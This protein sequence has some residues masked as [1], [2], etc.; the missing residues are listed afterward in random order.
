MATPSAPRDDLVRA[1]DT[2]VEFRAASDDSDDDGLGTLHGHFSVFGQPY[3]IDSVFEGRFMEVIAPGAF[4]DTIAQDRASMRV[5]FQHGQDPHIGSKPLGSIEELEED[6]TGARYSAKLLDTG[7][8][9]DLLPGLKA[10][11]YGASMRFTVLD[12]QWDDE[13]RKS[14]SNPDKLPERTITRARVA[15]FGPVTFPASPSATAGVRSL[16]D[17]FRAPPEERIEPAA[18]ATP[19]P[20]PK[21]TPVEV[22]KPATPADPIDEY[23]SVPE[24][25]EAV[26]ARKERM[27]ELDKEHEG[28]ELPPDAQAEFDTADTE[29][30]RLDARIEAVEKRR[31]QVEEAEARATHIPVGTDTP[32]PYSPPV[33]VPTRTDAELTDISHIRAISRSDDEYRQLMRDNAMRVLERT[34]APTDGKDFAADL[35][36]HK[37]TNDRQLARRVLAT[38]SPAYMRAFRKY[39]LGD[40]FTAEEQRAASLAVGVD[41]T[42]GFAVPF[43]FDPSILKTGAHAPNPYRQACRVETIVGTDTW[44]GVTANAVTVAYVTEA[45]PATEVGP[46]FTQNE[47]I[48]KRAHGYVAVSMEM[49]QDRADI[50]GELA[51][52]FAEAKD[53]YEEGQFAIGAGTTVYPEGVAL[54][55]AYTAVETIT[56]DVTAVADL[57]ATEAALPIRHRQGAAWFLSR[58]AIRAIQ[59][60]ETTGGQ[61]FGGQSYPAVGS[62]IAQG[63]NTGLRLLG[64]PVYESNSISWTPTTSPNIIGVLFEPSTYLIL[65][66]VGM[67]VE[68]IPHVFNGATP[69]FPTGQRGVYAYWRGTARVLNVDAGR[70][71]K[72]NA[73]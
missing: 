69:N 14:K 11:L 5:L 27:A 2:G 3:E 49:M 31:R 26:T 44:H 40:S 41:G 16:T 43:A 63:G 19:G 45:A 61:L 22:Q 21:E 13:P 37:D 54:D 1:M 17:S 65:D 67:N 8:V 10:N 35:L 64:Y 59:A 53:T 62:G 33:T 28:R 51:G 50:A 66:R 4:A 20:A 6:G 15:E 38:S 34:T 57:R 30:Q 32:P 12:D 36:D 55:G 7:Y 9:R 25:R 58:A 73:P 29:I 56:N 42:G 18:P 60:W 46:T 68:V 72:V 24:M 23:R 47:L 48:A 39:V 70:Q 71:I 52:L